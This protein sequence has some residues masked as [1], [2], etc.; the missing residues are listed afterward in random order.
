MLSNID[1]YEKYKP[2][3]AEYATIGWK[4]KKEKFAENHRE[5]LDAYNAAVRYFKSNLKINTYNRKDLEAER[6]QLTAALP[7]QRKELE[8][9]QAD[10]KI[11]RDVRH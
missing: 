9:V 7:G 5:E 3:H 11:L 6:K 10:A 2:T 1:K 8:A 4:K